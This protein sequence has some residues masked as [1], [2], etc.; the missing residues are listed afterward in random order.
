MGF[1]SLRAAQPSPSTATSRLQHLERTL[2]SRGGER[3][4]IAFRLEPRSPSALPAGGCART[5]AGPRPAGGCITQLREN[6]VQ[7]NSF[8]SQRKKR[9]K[10]SKNSKSRCGLH[11]QQSNFLFGIR[12]ATGHDTLKS[13][14][15]A[16]RLDLNT[17][18]CS[19][20]PSGPVYS[21]IANPDTLASDR[22]QNSRNSHTAALTA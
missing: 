18:Y 21:S 8:S 10:R 5:R 11:S 19:N 2:P 1:S 16:P 15:C 14:R 17:H 6:M 7:E 20:W 22:G 4:Y 3:K 9:R 13:S 12:P